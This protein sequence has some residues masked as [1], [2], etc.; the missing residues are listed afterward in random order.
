MY[1][2]LVG[3]LEKQGI[4]C[5]F[6][7]QCS[8]DTASEVVEVKANLQP[9]HLERIAPDSKTL[10]VPINTGWAPVAWQRCKRSSVGQFQMTRGHK[11]SQLNT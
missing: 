1:V 10:K 11:V 5:V 2:H 8:K 7:V 3:W 9:H 4:F 6:R